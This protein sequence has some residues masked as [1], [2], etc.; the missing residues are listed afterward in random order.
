MKRLVEVCDVLPSR[1][2]RLFALELTWLVSAQYARKEA[3]AVPGGLTAA[4]QREV[5]QLQQML[6]LVQDG[7]SNLDL[8]RFIRDRVK[9]GQS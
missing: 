6:E 5:R 3:L 2:D 7:E 4:R 8:E 9:G 1:D